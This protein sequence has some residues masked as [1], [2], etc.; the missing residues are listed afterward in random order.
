MISCLQR[1]RRG[2]PCSLLTPKHIAL[3]L[4]LL[5]SSLLDYIFLELFAHT[6]IFLDNG[7]ASW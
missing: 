2:E 4:H 5:A 1:L 3:L 6:C 7:G